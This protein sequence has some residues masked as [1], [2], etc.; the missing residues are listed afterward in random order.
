MRT[1]L[2]VLAVSTLGSTAL[3]PT[4][5]AQ[6]IRGQVADSVTRAPVG[7]GFVVL[8]G[9]GNQEIDRT[10]TTF[11]GRFTLPLPPDQRGPFRLRSERIGYRVAVTEPFDPAGTGAEFTLWVT[12]LPTALAT[13]EVQERTECKVRPSEDE[14]TAI[15]WEEARKALAAASWTASGERYHVVSDV[16]ERDMDRP[17]RRLIRERHRPAI[18]PSTTPFVSRDPMELLQGGYLSNADG[19]RFYYAPDAQVLQDEGFQETHC[20]RLRRPEDGRDNLIGL[21]FEPVPSRELPDVEGVL[22]LDRESSEL[23]TM[24]YRYTNLPR[25]LRGD[26]SAGGVVEFMPLPSGA[27]IVHRWR[28]GI[29][30]TLRE[31]LANPNAQYAWHWVQAFRYAGGEVLTITDSTGT[32]VYE[33]ELAEVTGVVEDSLRGDGVP[34]AGAV[35]QVPGTWFADTTDQDGVYRLG[36]PLDGEYGI[37]FTHPRADSMGYAPP[38]RRLTLTRGRTDTLRLAFPPMENVL[39]SFCPDHGAG[40]RVLVGTVRDAVTGQPAPGAEVVASWQR[41]YRNLE[42]RDL[43]REVT[44]DSA[45]TFVVCG[46][47]AGRPA[48]VYAA[49]DDDL[50]DMVRV[51]FAGTG[52]E[53]GNQHY[54]TYQ[55]AAGIW[56]RDLTLQRRGER[57]AVLAGLVTD[58]LSSRPIPGAKVNIG[59]E[60]LTAETDSTGMFRLEGPLSG[61]Q[62]IAVGRLGYGARSGEVEIEEDRPTIIGAQ[63]LALQPLAQVG[64]T[65]TEPETE[66]PVAEVWVTLMS[67]EGD[68]VRMT[69]TDSSGTFLLTAPEP[70][71]YYV[72]ARR[73]GY[74]PGF[75]GPFDLELGRQVEAALAMRQLAFALDPVN[76]TAEAVDQL[77]NDVGFYR[78]Q[79]S[80]HGYFM[81]RADIEERL[82]QA[83]QVSDLLT[84]VPGLNIP[85]D[86]AGSFGVPINVARRGCVGGPKIYVD[87]F[88]IQNTQLGGFS[89]EDT[90]APAWISLS[91]VVQPG[92]IYAIEIYRSEAQVP[93]EY[94]GRE[95]GCGVILIWTGRGGG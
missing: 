51:W 67:A 88:R 47:E 61:K 69:R 45:G 60:L 3:A 91:Q 66:A 79:R 27:W 41:V 8:L 58:A 19:E 6:T 49:H 26:G 77:L 9:P 44:T 42:F 78:R 62:R 39:A 29:P 10:L 13:I 65:I 2:L 89:L 18:G 64:G 93:V 21:A 12:A 80:S 94:G 38:A 40:D 84:H 35:V 24:E 4:L 23:R 43:E 22:W 55:T 17:R 83:H 52:V 90:P 11:D 86:L 72:R 32:L 7:R 25:N 50:S 85:A 59:G 37:T 48:V 16:Y 81:D 46:L 76:I 31:E 33:T 15:V 95:A 57:T 1:I 36:V 71:S 74:T 63:F 56:R 75:E 54:D 68:S 34:L 73:L 5:S 70:G 30:T 20:F 92:D 87:G 53:V 82:G 28:I 14:Q